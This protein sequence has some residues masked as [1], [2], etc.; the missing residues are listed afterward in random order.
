MIYFLGTDIARLDSFPRNLIIDHHKVFVK[1]ALS[2]PRTE[3]RSA[4]VVY[5]ITSKPPGTIERE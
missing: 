4:R 3:V 1:A 2:M 5:D